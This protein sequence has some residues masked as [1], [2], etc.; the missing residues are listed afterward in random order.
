MT[1]LIIVESGVCTDE[2]NPGKYTFLRPGV[3]GT[4]LVTTARV[5]EDRSVTSENQEFT[6]PDALDQ[7]LDLAHKREGLVIVGSGE[8]CDVPKIT[9]KL[10]VRGQSLRISTIPVAFPVPIED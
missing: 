5:K 8:G 10:L 3:D 7:A 4:W 1:R 2:C 9:N 6:E